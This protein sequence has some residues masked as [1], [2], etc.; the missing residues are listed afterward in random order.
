MKAMLN[1]DRLPCFLNAVQPISGLEP[2]NLGSLPGPDDI[3]R[4]PL[5]NGIVVLARANFNSPSVVISGYLPAGGL[6][7]PDDQLGLASF[8]ASGLMRGTASHTF[9][10]IYDLLESAGASLGFN[11]GTHTTGFGGRAL[12]DDLDLLLRILGD[13]LRSPSFPLE[14]VERLRAQILTGL[15]IRAQDTGE[16]A[17]LT[18]DQ[19][20]YAGHPY[21]RPEDGY[22]ETVQGISREDL[23][24]FHKVHYGPRG[25]VIA[26]VGAIDP[27]QAVEKVARVLGDWENPE[28]PVPP[29]LP[30]LNLPE[31]QPLR[32]VEIPGK[33]Q[34]DIILG[35]AGPTRRSPDFFPAALGNSILGQFGMMGRIGDAVREQAGLAYYAYSSLAAGS[36][37][38]PWEVIAGVDAAHVDRAIELILEEL[39]RFTSEPVATEELEDSK[40]SFIG[41]LPLSL[42]SNSGVAT[43]LVNLERYD[44]GLDYYQRYPGLV[45]EVTADQV[46][47]TARRYL[48]SGRLA[49]AVAGPQGI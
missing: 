28:Q 33:Y 27:D 38:G 39:G 6:F 17:S 22:P 24:A 46:L 8:T 47:E 49:T 35:S 7:D 21:A 14:N 44:L 48:S 41:R 1:P 2:E 4:V 32:K 34:A 5:G 25:M 19:I 42:E 20:V 10:E 16:M 15:A 12:V 37:P 29:E 43:A 31:G 45:Q 26:V 23:A 18:F 11:G 30:P 36:G 13:A 40:A 9:Q 3:R